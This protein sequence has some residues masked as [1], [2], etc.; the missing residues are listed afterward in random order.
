MSITNPRS[1]KH[2]AYEIFRKYGTTVIPEAPIGQECA[3]GNIAFI[4]PSDRENTPEVAYWERK[5]KTRLIKIADIHNG[6]AELYIASDERVFVI[7]DV[8]GQFCFCSDSIEG[9]I[10]NIVNGIRTQPLFKPF[11][12]KI[13]LYGETY[14]RNDARNYR[15]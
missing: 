7:D 5:L 6:Y 11:Q 14:R 2:P 8:V 15:V 13:V 9:A 1:F 3:P 4:Q 12:W 10:E